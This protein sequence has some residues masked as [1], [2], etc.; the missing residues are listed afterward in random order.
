MS[1]DPDGDSEMMSSSSSSSETSNPQTPTVNHTAGPS[2]SISAIE[3]SPPGSQGPPKNDPSMN[4]KREIADLA[5]QVES[6]RKNCGQSIDEATAIVRDAPGSAW[7]NKSAEEA[8]QHALE[9]VIH[10]DF[11]LNEFGDPFD[12]RNMDLEK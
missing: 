2:I 10:H 8:Y 7:M 4:T 6:S 5:I 11:S 12:D 1:P 3:L 9:F